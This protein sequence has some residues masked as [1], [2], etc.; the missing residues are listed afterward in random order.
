V[1]DL[2]GRPGKGAVTLLCVTWKARRRRSLA[3]MVVLITTLAAGASCAF[4]F[5][6]QRHFK[7]H[8][9]GGVFQTLVGTNKGRVVLGFG[10][11]RRGG[12][13][14]L[15]VEDPAKKTV[16]HRFQLGYVKSSGA[17]LSLLYWDQHFSH[18]LKGHYKASWFKGGS[19]FGPAL[20]FSHH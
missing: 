10:I 13:Y 17:F 9:Y 20:G 5:S 6:I 8:R 1:L 16:C 12:I 14:R 2:P 11:V 15:C 4:A 3:V 7:G 18:T 19:R